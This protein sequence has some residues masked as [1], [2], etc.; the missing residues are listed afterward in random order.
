M[1]NLEVKL[2]ELGVLEAANKNLKAQGGFSSIENVGKEIGIP[3]NMVALGGCFRWSDS[4]EGHNFWNDI[5]DKLKE[6][7]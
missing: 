3:Q 2:K 6:L 5:D 1:K 4:P 7:N